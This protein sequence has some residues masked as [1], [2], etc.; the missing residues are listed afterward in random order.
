MPHTNTQYP[1][2]FFH[3]MRIDGKHLIGHLWILVMIWLI[4][5]DVRVFSRICRRVHKN[6]R[7]EER[8]K[9]KKDNELD[10]STRYLYNSETITIMN[11]FVKGKTELPL[12]MEFLWR[13]TV[14]GCWNAYP[15][16]MFESMRITEWSKI[17]GN[18]ATFH[19][20]PDCYWIRSIS[21]VSTGK[22]WKNPPRACHF[23]WPRSHEK[24]SKL[25]FS[26]SNVPFEVYCS[27]GYR[28]FV[29]LRGAIDF[30]WSFH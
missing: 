7:S 13:Q 2:S 5:S 3:C 12:G 14:H 23:K 24:R 30:S 22:A 26:K 10:L 15:Q 6:A 4:A 28:F 9:Q 20:H 21:M 25:H 29:E 8:E 17:K 16:T 11:M 19:S 18:Q 27:S 1:N